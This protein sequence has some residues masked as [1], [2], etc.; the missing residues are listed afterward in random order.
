MELIKWNNA[1]HAQLNQLKTYDCQCGHCNNNC[2]IYFNRED[3]KELN[4]GKE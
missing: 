4:N 2:L 3:F 1:K